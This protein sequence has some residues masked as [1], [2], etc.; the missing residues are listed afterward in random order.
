MKQFKDRR[1][2]IKT[3]AL[4]GFGVGISAGSF[5]SSTEA[6]KKPALPYTGEQVR[7]GM[8][9]LDTSH[10]LAFTGML[11]GETAKEGLEGYRL[12]AAYPQGSKDIESSTKR[13]P[14]IT[15]GMKKLGV[16]IVSSI[17]ELLTKVDVVML[18]TNDGRPH[19]EQALPV[20][21][22]RKRL[23]I[24]KPIAASLADAMAIFAA[25]EKYD[26][27]VFSSSSLRF[28]AGMKEIAE[29]AKIGKI[30][31]AD[32]YSPCEIEK[33]HP[34]LFW[35]GIHGVEQLFT[36]MGTGC[37][38]VVRVHTEGTDMVVGTWEGKRIGTFRGTR[39]G[40]HDYG[41][42]AFGE[43]GTTPIPPY[44]GY[45]P[46]LLEIIKFFKTGKVPVSPQETLEI[47]A[48]MEAADESKKK[49]G[50]PVSLEAMFKRAKKIKR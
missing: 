31:G 50:A 27:P 14:E 46:L 16:E 26:T 5:A 30:V 40:S 34:D 47:C 2:F 15:E 8:I 41:G 29:G 12:V 19:L 43:K 9:G 38:E 24:D 20:L 21:K 22:A 42:T 1:N 18:E 17:E 32:C 6:K 10:C 4:A 37:S 25:A 23:F 36:V 13:V 33:T 44:S 39:E 49:G 11:N 35:Y 28:A 45:E 7:V 48:F 3:A